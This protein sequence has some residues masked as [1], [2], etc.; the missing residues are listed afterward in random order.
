MDQLSEIEVFIGI[1]FI[2]MMFH[3]CCQN[4]RWDVVWQKKKKK[5]IYIYIHSCVWHKQKKK[6]HMH[7]SGLCGRWDASS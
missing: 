2:F 4:S 7:A 1:N 5:N 3:I 6:M